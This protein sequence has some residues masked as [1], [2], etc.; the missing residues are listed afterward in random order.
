[1]HCKPCGDGFMFELHVIEMDVGYREKN[2]I[3]VLY[4]AC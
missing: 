2:N 3:F 4:K 1:M